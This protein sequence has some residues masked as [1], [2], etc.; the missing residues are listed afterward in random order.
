MERGE[1]RLHCD[2]RGTRDISTSDCVSCRFEGRIRLRDK[3]RSMRSRGTAL[4]KAGDLCCRVSRRRALPWLA[5]NLVRAVVA[6]S[7]RKRL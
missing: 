6:A 7:Y 4:A 1:A 3:R 5:A 2:K